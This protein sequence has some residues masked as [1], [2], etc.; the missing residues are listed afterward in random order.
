M[1]TLSRA[2]A[3]FLVFVCIGV[4]AEFIVPPAPAG[5]ILDEAG[6]LSAAENQSLEQ[7]ITSLE[8]ETHHQIGIAIMKSLQ[9]RSIEEVGITLGRT[10]GVGQKELDNGLLIVMAPTEREVRIEVGRGLE[11]V[12]TDLIANRIID[13]YIIPEFKQEAYYSWLSRAIE[14]MSPLLRGEVVDLP[15][16]KSSIIDLITP[17]LFLILFFG[18]SFLSILSASKSWWLWGV[19]WAI[20][21][22]MIGWISAGGIGLGVGLILDFFLS[23][24]A[25]QKI[26]LIRN[27]QSRHSGGFGGGSGGGWGWFGGGW[28]GW[29]GASGRW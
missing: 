24:Y 29:G 5:H 18:W 17:F 27:F 20:I 19:F 12:I 6:I 3:I 1:N 13:D 23:K 21:W 4:L 26:P 2:C 22:G 25:Y 7:T 9:G 10:W 15:A 11:W 16:M 8:T 28:F 14:V